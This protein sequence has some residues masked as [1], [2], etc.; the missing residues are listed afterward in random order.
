MRSVV[1]VGNPRPASRTLAAATS[2]CE[3]LTGAPPRRSFDLIEFGAALFDA[4]D[5]QVCEAVAS[6]RASDLVIVASP[7]YKG[8]YTGVLKL[9]LDHFAPGS[10]SSVVA[11]PVMVGGLPKHALAPEVFLKPVLVE[12][13]ASCPTSSVF[14]LESELQNLAVLEAWLADSWPKLGLASAKA[15]T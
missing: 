5:E 15:T 10:L 8:A 6:V 2:I 4:S 1:V 12:L 3:R 13:G 9:F 11:V 14:L 7:V